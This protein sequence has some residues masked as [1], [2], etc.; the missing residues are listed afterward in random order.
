MSLADDFTNGFAQGFS[1]V[2]KGFLGRHYKEG[3]YDPFILLG[4]FIGL[5]VGAVLFIKGLKEHMKM[6]RIEDTPTSKIGSIA[7]GYVE[8]AGKV[9]NGSETLKSPLTGKDCMYYRDIVEERKIDM[10]GRSTGWYGISDAE[11]S[12]PFYVK[13][14]TGSVLVEPNGACVE[15]ASFRERENNKKDDGFGQ[16][17]DRRHTVYTLEEGD[18]VFLHGEAGIKG[19]ENVI[20]KG[21]ECFFISD[22]PEKKIL[23]EGRRDVFLCVYGGAATTLAALAVILYYLRMI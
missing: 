19:G 15:L 9:A 20:K 18:T 4:A 7:M 3:M 8:V 13:D 11:A 23:K 21:R 2:G 22:R 12:V 1:I 16:I 14:E 17:V 6:R 10:R 5:F